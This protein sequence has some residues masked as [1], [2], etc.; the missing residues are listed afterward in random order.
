MICTA[1]HNGCEISACAIREVSAGASSSALSDQSGPSGRTDRDS[2]SSS[3][4]LNAVVDDKMS[5][6]PMVAH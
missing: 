4:I 6:F 5:S 1:V 3:M 2:S